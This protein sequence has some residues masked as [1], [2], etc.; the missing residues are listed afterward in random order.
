MNCVFNSAFVFF[1][2]KTAYEMRISDWSSD[3]C[4]S[5]LETA[6][7][8]GILAKIAVAR[9]RREIRDQRGGVILEVRPFGMARHLG[10][11]PGREPCITVAKLQLGLG[12]RK[13]V[14]SGKSVSVSVY[15]GG[16]RI[17]KTKLLSAMQR[18]PPTT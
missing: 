4:S 13:S 6:G 18:K 5:D 17:I 14:V 2:Q 15:L 10:A 11:L 16:R 1:K 12:A 3:V 8:R 7:D 9:Q